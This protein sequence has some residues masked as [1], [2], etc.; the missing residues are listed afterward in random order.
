MADDF[1]LAIELRHRNVRTGMG[2]QLDHTT[3][4]VIVVVELNP[5]QLAALDMNVGAAVWRKAGL[6][7]GNDAASDLALTPALMQRGR[8]HYEDFVRTDPKC[9]L[10]LVDYGARDTPL[11]DH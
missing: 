1:P 9:T 6:L 7:L 8:P 5:A 2:V 11:F 3:L 4:A 10:R